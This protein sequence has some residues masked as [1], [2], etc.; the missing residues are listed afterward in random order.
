METKITL[1]RNQALEIKR[2]CSLGITMFQHSSN[3]KRAKKYYKLLERKLEKF[4]AESDNDP[5]GKLQEN[6]SN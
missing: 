1:T 4:R 3:V 5:D 2:V 6:F